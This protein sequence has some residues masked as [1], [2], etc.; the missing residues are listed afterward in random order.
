MWPVGFEPSVTTGTTCLLFWQQRAH[1]SGTGR[2]PKVS[3]MSEDR[4]P[5]AAA[6]P[7]FHPPSIFLATKQCTNAESVVPSGL[8]VYTTSE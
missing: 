8:V 7:V 4:K 2:N 5:A 3:Y 1:D 6:R